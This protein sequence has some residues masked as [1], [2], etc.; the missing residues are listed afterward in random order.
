[1]HITFQNHLTNLSA[2]TDLFL[3][4]NIPK[5]FSGDRKLQSGLYETA[6][7]A[8][9]IAKV[10][11]SPESSEDRDDADRGSSYARAVAGV[12]QVLYETQLANGDVEIGV[13]EDGV[14]QVLE[15]VQTCE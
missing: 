10:Q 8:L 6:S 15:V 7:R 11:I 5:D 1:M 3:P 13:W 12:L 2:A 4:L 9:Q 14:R